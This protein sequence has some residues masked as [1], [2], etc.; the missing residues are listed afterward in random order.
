MISGDYS[1][2]R[3]V[4]FDEISLKAVFGLRKLRNTLKTTKKKHILMKALAFAPDNLKFNLKFPVFLAHV[5]KYV[6]HAL[7]IVA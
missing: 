1:G 3:L 2:L 6:T 4:R 7:K 5:L